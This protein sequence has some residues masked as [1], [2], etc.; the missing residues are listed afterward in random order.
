M[1]SDDSKLVS[2]SK[3]VDGKV[4]E[5]VVLFD[6]VDLEYEINE[7]GQNIL[8][9]VHTMDEKSLKNITKKFAKWLYSGLNLYHHLTK[10]KNGDYESLK[11][12]CDMY[13]WLGNNA[14][15]SIKY[16]FDPILREELRDIFT[17][18]PPEEAQE[19]IIEYNKSKKENQIKRILSVNN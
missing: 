17:V 19:A 11:L 18:L 7:L 4:E 14:E 6:E 13:G 8:R 9:W 15:Q 3:I 12:I 10:I 1:L 2:V 16:D 5:Y